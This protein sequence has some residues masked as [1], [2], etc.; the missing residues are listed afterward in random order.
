MEVPILDGEDHEVGDPSGGIRRV[1]HAGP[2][3]LTVD[4][5]PVTLQPFS[6]RTARYEPH[7]KPGVREVR[8]VHAAHRSGP[9]HSDT[10]DP[11]DP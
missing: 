4:D 10:F 5:E 11:L 7:I 8:G 3:R 2:Q 9:Q 6:T 1:D